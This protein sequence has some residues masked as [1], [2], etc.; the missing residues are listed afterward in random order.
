[1]IKK[2]LSLF[3]TSVRYLI[4]TGVPIDQVA[5]MPVLHC[6]VLLCIFNKKDSSF[7]RTKI[8]FKGNKKRN[9]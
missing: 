5:M 2:R 4:D 3:L 1:M 7:I 6:L 9:S 8:D